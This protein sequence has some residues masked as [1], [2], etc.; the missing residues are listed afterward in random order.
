MTQKQ[1]TD[2]LKLTSPAR[3]GG[4]NISYRKLIIFCS[5]IRRCKVFAMDTPRP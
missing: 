4:A 2:S 1:V 5:L 3:L